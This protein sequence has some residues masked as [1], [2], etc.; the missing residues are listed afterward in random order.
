M[1]RGFAPVP[2]TYYSISAPKKQPA[3]ARIPLH[4]VLDIHLP[5]PTVFVAGADRRLQGTPS[6]RSA[7]LGT[8]RTGQPRC[9][10]LQHTRASGKPSLLTPALRA[11]T[12]A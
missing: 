11:Q 7:L 10:L 6:T 3:L 12:T 5:Q 2:T 9:P 8:G 4:V 1:R